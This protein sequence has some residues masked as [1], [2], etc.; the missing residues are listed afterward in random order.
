MAL[1]HRVTTI[2]SARKIVPKRR[3]SSAL[4]SKRHLC[5]AAMTE[6]GIQTNDSVQRSVWNVALK[7]TQMEGASPNSASTVLKFLASAGRQYFL[8]ARFAPR[9]AKR[10]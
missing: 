9:E 7:C 2:P 1:R 10:K 3:H 4:Q 5:G 6:I 8:S